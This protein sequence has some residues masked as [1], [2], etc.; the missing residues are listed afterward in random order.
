MVHK[1]FNKLAVFPVAAAI[2][3]VSSMAVTQSVAAQTSCSVRVLLENAA[4]P[5]NSPSEVSGNLTFSDAVSTQTASIPASTNAMNSA[6]LYVN[7]RD[8]PV[9]IDS[10]TITDDD[11]AKTPVFDG[12]LLA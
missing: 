8:C 9:R 7:E 2:V 4:F 11:G 1:L 6:I 5:D 3:F 10:I 12:C